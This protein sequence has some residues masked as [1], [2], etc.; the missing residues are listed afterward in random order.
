MSPPAK[1]RR[2]CSIEQV[3]KQRNGKPR[4]WCST[5]QAPA[6]G[7]Y[8]VRLSVCE[9]AYRDTEYTDVLRL[10]PE[11]YP[12]G[13]ALW[14]AVAPVYDTTGGEPEAGIHVHARPN[15]GG[16]KAIDKTFEAVE[17]Q[18]SSDLFNSGKAVITRETAVNYYIS[19]FLG[20]KIK[21]LYCIH[22]G[23]LHLDAGFFAVKPHR[24]HLCHGCGKY[25]RD[26]ERGVSNPIWLMR[27]R[28][29]ASQT[30]HSLVRPDRTLDI[31]QADYPGGIQVW[32]SNPAL[33]WTADRP[34]EEGL[35]VHAFDAQG[36]Y[37]IDDTFGEVRVNGELL[38]EEH[39]A[40]FMAQSALGYLK[41]KVLA[42]HCPNCGHAHFDQGEQ[43]FFPHVWHQCEGCGA[44][45]HSPGRRRLC[46]SNPFVETKTRLLSG[47]LRPRTH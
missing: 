33:V 20:R 40:H 15:S 9:A 11:Q 38:N 39:I 16:R 12:G 43:A 41:G 21:H 13:I 30:R 14:G 32:A 36:R 25:F 8:G 44:K 2:A 42:L 24:R 23:E 22:C 5:H 26:S 27:E 47:D 29:D 10:D 7:R 35:H 28:I 31:R 34:E 45:F 18:Y 6:T 1:P 37:V 46:V 19:Q 17:L 3:G 4:F